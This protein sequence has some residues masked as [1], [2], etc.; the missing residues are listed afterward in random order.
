MIGRYDGETFERYGLT[1]RVVIEPDDGM[2]TPWEEHDG[3][4]AVSDHKPRR[5]KKPGEVWL[6]SDEGRDS[7][8]FYDW[9]GAIEK[10]K[11]EGW[12]I[13]VSE[14]LALAWRLK[15]Y[16]TAKQIRVEAVRRDFEHLKAWCNDEWYWVRVGLVVLDDDGNESNYEG[17]GGVESDC[18]EYINELLDGGVEELAQ[19]VLGSHVYH[20]HKVL[21]KEAA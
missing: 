13:G 12:G 7:H 10:A 21:E 19:R 20:M 8:R 17:C 11:N 3:H 9:E 18:E 6:C 5:N 15:R 4:G 16:P 2:K 14:I 1:F